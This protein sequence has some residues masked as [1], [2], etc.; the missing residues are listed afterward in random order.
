[1]N[2]KRIEI[3]D[4]VK[5]F[6]DHI[7]CDINGIILDTP[8]QGSEY[9]IIDSTSGIVYLGFGF[10]IMRLVEKGKK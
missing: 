1:M 2:K 6:N 3:G 8:C 4:T 7:D 5:V 10:Y 9:W